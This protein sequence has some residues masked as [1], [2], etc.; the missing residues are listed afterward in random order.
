VDP[1]TSDRSQLLVR[2]KTETKQWAYGVRRAPPIDNDEQ[3]NR[4]TEG[5][6]SGEIKD[7]FYFNFYDY[8]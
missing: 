3:I 5:S 1:T 7:N 2:N 4:T 6:Q 8:I